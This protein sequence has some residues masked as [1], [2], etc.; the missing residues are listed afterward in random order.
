MDWRRWR[1]PVSVLALAIGVVGGNCS[2]SRA[3]VL[4]QR[5]VPARVAIRGA[6]SDA[7]SDSLDNVFITPDR[8]VLQQLAKA[9]TLLQDE[10]YADAIE[11]LDKV[12]ENSEDYFFQ[13][14]KDAPMVHRSLKAEA[15][16]LIGQMPRKGLDLYQLKFGKDAE[17]AL[18]KAKKSGDAGALAYVSRRFFHTRAGY[19]ATFLLGLHHL[20]HGRPLA[21]GLTLQRL[22][23]AAGSAV[24]F[25]PALSLTVASCWLQVGMP[26]KA[27][28]LLRDLKDD[29]GEHPL[30]IAGQQVR[31]FAK[32]KESLSWL[33]SL[34]G[35]QLVFSAAE[36]DSWAMFLGNPARNATT[37]GSA[38]LL[39][40]LWEIP[41]ASDNPVVDEII[42]RYRQ[43]C[44]ERDQ[45]TLP[46]LHPL[47]IDDVVLMRTPR[48]LLAVEFATGRRL[49]ESTEGTLDHGLQKQLEDTTPELLMRQWP[50][51]AQ[52]LWQR[53]WNDT[54]YG[55]VSSD[56]RYVFT[57]E[58]LDVGFGPYRS[59]TVVIGGRIQNTP[60]VLYNRLAAYDIHSGKI[61]WNL[62]GPAD[63]FALP[64]AET[65]FLGPPLP[66][67]GQLYVLAERRGQ[68][69]IA[70]LA[71]DAKKGTVLWSQ[72][73]AMAERD[74]REDPVRRTSGASPSYADGILVCPTS[75]GAV[76]AVDLASRA[77]LWG[78]NYR[79]SDSGN[80]YAMG[81]AVMVAGPFGG[82]TY[83]AAPQQSRWADASVTVADGRVL[84]TPADSDALHCLSLVDGKLLWT[85]DRR[86]ERH[87][88][89]YL[90]CVHQDKAV[91]VGRH[92][93]R[94]VSLSETF[95]ET[96]TVDIQETTGGVMRTVRKEVTCARPKPA[97]DGRTVAFPEGSTPSGRG[98]LTGNQ[99]YLPLSSAEVVAVDLQA[100][101]ISRASKS[102]EGTV[103]GNLVCY[104]GKV[105][106]Q[107]FHGLATFYQLDA[108][109]DEVGRRLAAN[110]GDAEALSLRGE[111]LL[112]E[113]KQ[114][115][116]IAC[117][118]RAYEMTKEPDK[119]LRTRGLLRDALL[120]GLR[121]RFAEYRARSEEIEKLLDDTSQRATY[122]RLMAAGLQESGDPLGALR[123]YE[124]LVD[125]DQPRQQIEAV[126]P[127]HSVRRD[128]WIQARL[129][130]LRAEV[131]D[132]AVLAEI[133]RAIAA[134]LEA[135]VRSGKA[136]PL[137]RFLDYFGN[138]PIAGAAR[139]E[140]IRR[141][142]ESDRLLEA[143]LVLWNDQQS[144]DPAV[145]GP[146]VAELGEMLRKA[147]RDADAALCYRRLAKEFAAV[148][149]A[150]GKTGKQLVDAL[151]E[152]SPAGRWLGAAAE[153]PVG[154]VDAETQREQSGRQPIYNRFAL[155]LD[156]NVGPFF[157]DAMVQFDQNRRC[158]L[159]YDGW[160]AERWQLP[161]AETSLQ[162]FYYNRAMPPQGYVHGHL[163]L[164]SM[165]FRLLAIDMLDTKGTPERPS[166]RLLWEQDLTGSTFDPNTINALGF[167]GVMI[168]GGNWVGVQ[169]A[170]Y[171]RQ[172]N[173]A[174][175]V[176][177][178]TSRYVCFQRYRNLVALDPLTGD[179]LWV[180]HNVPPGS[181]LFGDDEF[182]FALPPD[183]SEALVF[184][185]LDGQLLGKRP[186]PR[187]PVD[188][189]NYVAVAPARVQPVQ[190]LKYVP[191]QQTCLDT[192]GRK[193]LLWYR[194]VDAQKGEHRVLELFDPWE[195]R[196][197]WPPRI[198]PPAAVADMVGTEAVGIWEPDGR[199]LLL[200][201][202]DGRTIVDAKLAV[203]GPFGPMTR[204]GVLKYLDQYI[205]L[206]SNPP[207]DNP[208]PRN[209][210]PLPWTNPPQPIVRGW[211]YAFDSQGKPA[212]PEPVEVQNQYFQAEQQPSLLP[213]L[214]FACQEFIRQGNTGRNQMSFLCLDKRTGRKLY[215]AKEPDG[216]FPNAMGTFEIVGDPK[217][218]SVQLRMQ[219]HTVVL[220]FTDQ[221]LPPP[222]TNDKAPE[223]P[224]GGKTANALRKALGKSFRQG[225]EMALP[226][227]RGP[228][229]PPGLL[230][231]EEE[232]PLPAIPVPPLR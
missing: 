206:T 61:M 205:V 42:R 173:R 212:W 156:G 69:E 137:R 230:E 48:K 138:Q 151:G 76:V 129:A 186:I 58:D 13:P 93:M 204:L 120:E 97:W 169:S 59:R 144:A 215:P 163:L 92:E 91:L 84:V 150:E 64:E 127:A 114:T 185:A 77:L 85:C 153:W 18:A 46:G 12:L 108:T 198:F 175:I 225:P 211:V 168:Q 82:T 145:A 232:E 89:L 213:V 123:Q 95:S 170:R 113:G 86:G 10:L 110:A 19:E 66:L 112:D 63:Q 43:D 68:M 166:P 178:C 195:N 21:A 220:K 119:A 31:W 126:T 228:E 141:L 47:A 2:A 71:L 194:K 78:Y 164:I 103:P 45:L 6:N 99:Y 133:D 208:N 210:Q 130:S 191:F 111:I 121:L 117:F 143:E 200:G 154:R 162:N 226:W 135:A 196:S 187:V 122:V 197:V 118:R 149:C 161:L 182:V 158:I 100:G 152:D 180:C 60:A 57:V 88:D 124:K 217:E 106:S 22:R 3:Q 37:I 11:L 177:P 56:G 40:R 79:R 155:R 35:S 53:M 90:A 16:R 116:A 14:D 98:F 15:Q 32:D 72:P 179:V 25:E 227:P 139:H 214:T 219:Q 160:G 107:G 83:Q 172:V 54:T 73:L 134:R 171:G 49:W 146:A 28:E 109:R 216:N 8:N 94:A 157:S 207:A 221:P 17:N 7:V 223:K 96:K 41:P 165:G 1:L 159:A 189:G 50:Q 62:G 167:Q 183:Q 55:T 52:G 229:V 65:Y 20:D 70:L 34:I 125:L 184:R 101:R 81:G 67:M 203:G 33:R 36:P 231:E 102:R 176:G 188:S 209:I 202:P 148:I 39:N 190:P 30:T 222:A 142:A 192:L 131:K 38:P 128:R 218:H 26:E 140:L 87:E 44:A 75:V 193:A 199:F 224:K 51:V 105:I 115:E 74:L 201:L 23:E 5:A 27:R 181:E 24:S 80:R 4:L 29:Y 174:N 9:R 104:K 132:A 136:D 147:K